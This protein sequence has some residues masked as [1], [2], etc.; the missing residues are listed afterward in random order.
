MKQG[1][2][3]STLAILLLASFDARSQ[4]A[5]DLA[6]AGPEDITNEN[7]PDIVESFDY[8]DADIEEVVKA[9]SKL[10]QKN[11]IIDRGVKGKIS[12][13]APTQITVAEAYRA[14]LS[15]LAMNGYTVV[16]QGKFL[17]IRKSKEA[18]RDSIETYSG[19]YYPDTDQ[20]IT[21][22]AKLKYI[23]AGE[24]QK[25]IRGLISPDGNLAAYDLTN[26]LIITD[27]GSNIARIMSILEELDVKGFDEQ[28][29]VIRV[30]YAKVR[31]IRYIISNIIRSRNN[32]YGASRRLSRFRNVPS[33][34]NKESFSFV[35]SDDRTNSIIVVGNKVGI[36]KV[37]SLIRKLDIPTQADKFGG[38]YVYY[39]KY[40]NAKKIADIVNKVS[41]TTQQIIR[42]QSRESNV[43]TLRSQR[44]STQAREQRQDGGFFGGDVKVTADEET[45]SLVVVASRSDFEVLK[46]LLKRIDIPRDQV[47]VQ[48]V[49]ME[50]RAE[51]NFNFGVSFMKFFQDSEEGTTGIGRV[52]FLTG[53]G[54][55]GL[56]SPQHDEG[57]ISFAD[58]S[59]LLKLAAGP[60]Q[61]A[62]G[63]ITQIPHLAGFVEFLKTN[64][65]G[66]ILSA[67]QVMALDNSKALISV[68]DSVT[69][70]K[71]V[72]QDNQ[73]I[74]T[75]GN[76]VEANIKLEI[77][78][79]INPSTD[80]VK[81]QVSQEANDFT[82]ESKQS[83]APDL[84]KRQIE[85]TIIVNSGDTAVLGGLMKDK[86]ENSETK[87]P[88]LGD[89]PLL[90]WFFKRKENKKTKSN[91]IVFLTPRIIRNKGENSKLL[92]DKVN[93]R[94]QFIQRN[95]HGLDPHG[96]VVESLPR[97]SSLDN[98]LPEVP[99]HR[100]NEEVPLTPG[101]EGVETPRSIEYDKEVLKPAIPSPEELIPSAP[102]EVPSPFLPEN[103]KKQESEIPSSPLINLEGGEYKEDEDRLKK[104]KKKK[105]KGVDEEEDDEEEEDEEFI[106][107]EKELLES[108]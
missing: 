58:S 94:I 21:R 26:S 36:N 45:N 52:G 7:F 44:Q 66:N 1:M 100:D 10:T 22:I 87:I 23:N 6:T 12:I 49:I 14:F 9:I 64:A 59:N 32:P 51:R 46:T 30:Q 92:K 69:T 95:M 98:E 31:S 13:I 74:T 34:K 27:Y 40:A 33:N 93:E 77:T 39:V 18:R 68:G 89:I 103:L 80:Q 81:L 8:P 29:A 88:I 43:S 55:N 70:T 62:L 20:V 79:S 61:A 56:F 24:I 60:L 38:V 37:R 84:L 35:D 107:L 41:S 78:P 53:R 50:L 2:V 16:P 28:L 108:F 106:E 3:L 11:F 4:E 82:N 54:L 47:F 102:E 57:I 104:K 99:F 42:Q 25:G 101:E 75:A 5:P 105:G 76:V 71:Q 19:K 86:V 65:G 96:S 15:A 72:F 91:L 17:K 67:P 85:T 48:A 97:L 90:G 83:V 63:G 73:S